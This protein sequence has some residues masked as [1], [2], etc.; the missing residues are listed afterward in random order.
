MIKELFKEYR[1][2]TLKA[3]D[4]IKNNEDVSEYFERRQIA[5]EKINSLGLSK[6]EIRREYC[7]FGL[8][9][10][11]GELKNVLVLADKDIKEKIS[12]SKKRRSAFSTYAANG[13]GISLFSQ[14]V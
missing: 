1:I 5:L 10:L 12:N 7:G 8:L 4:G 11:D 9:E 2:A 3:I 6:D 13:R 14:R